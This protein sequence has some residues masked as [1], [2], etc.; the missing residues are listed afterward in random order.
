[1]F[2]TPTLEAGKV[3]AYTLKAEIVRDGQTVTASRRVTVQAPD[4]AGRAAILAV[5][6]RKGMTHVI[7]FSKEILKAEWK[8]DTPRHDAPAD[9][10]ARAWAKREARMKRAVEQHRP[11]DRRG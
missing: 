7:L 5:H 2:A 3:Y 8:A 10:R 1:M 9:K 4:R 6:T 11:R